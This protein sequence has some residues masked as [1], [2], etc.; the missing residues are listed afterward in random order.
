MG[1]RVDSEKNIDVEKVKRFWVEEAEESLLVAEHLVEKEDYSYA[2]FFG[3]LALEKMI[4]GFCVVT[5]K[6][7]APPVHKAG[8]GDR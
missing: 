4:K 3:H 1:E 5:R 6:E 2:L 7:H 8:H